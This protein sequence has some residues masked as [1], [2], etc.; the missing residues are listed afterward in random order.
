MAALIAALD[1]DDF[2][3]REKAS[4]D[5]GELGVS[6]EAAL[7]KALQNK[8]SPEVER[9]IKALLEQLPQMR[10]PGMPLQSWRAV[11]VLE[12]IGNTSA[13]RVLQAL[14]EGDP[15]AR[16]TQE[17]GAALVRLARSQS[18]QGKQ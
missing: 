16:L 10:L 1:G 18:G 8:P 2:A 4:K 11:T 13:R 12:R 14:S 5:L 7:R 15:E 9:R 6:A 3:M 17:A